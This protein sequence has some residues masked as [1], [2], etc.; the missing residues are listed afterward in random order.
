MKMILAS[1]S[2]RRYEILKNLGYDFSVKVADVDE[3]C[4]SNIPKDFVK[5]LA[6]KKANAVAKTVDN[7]CFVIGCDT[8]VAIENKILGKPI[9][10]ND[11]E[12]MLKMLSGNKH[13][14]YSGLC[15]IKGE[16]VL[17]D[18][19]KTDVYFDTFSQ[20]DIDAYLAEKE[21]EDKAGSYAIQGKAGVFVNRIDG[22]YF[23]VVGLPINLL[24]NMLKKF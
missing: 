16:K 19:C 23:N 21:F 4:E 7:D 24:H 11:A 13:S 12:K 9:D 20:N 18:Y 15:I 10:K 3:N 8:V 2:P 1:K 22:E 17:V 5:E 14:V 6:F